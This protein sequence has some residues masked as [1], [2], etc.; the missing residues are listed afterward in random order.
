[1][2]HPAYISHLKQ[3]SIMSETIILVHGLWMTGLEL[4]ILKH[5]LESHDYHCVMFSYASVTGSMVDHV[6][7]LRE[8]AHDTAKQGC[9]RLHFVGHSLGGL[10]CYKLLESTHDLPPGRAV[11]LGTPVQ[12]S[13]AMQAMSQWNLGRAV[14]GDDALSELLPGVNRIWDGRRDLGI[15]A[16]SSNIGL[17]RMF[18]SDLSHDSDGTVRIAETQLPG[19]KDHI[20]LPVSHTS[21]VFAN[22]VVHQVVCFLRDGKFE[23]SQSG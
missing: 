1:M 18:S 19:A 5:R 9:T 10:V 6:R 2:R 21:M 22:E 13:R 20:V 3:R 15:I 11:F 23:H 8:L 4:T 16:G 17:G 14:V 12:G 7:K